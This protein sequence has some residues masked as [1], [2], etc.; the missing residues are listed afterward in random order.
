MKHIATFLITFLIGLAS[1]FADFGSV[2]THAQ[3]KRYPNELKDYEFFGS[4]RLKPIVLGSST[5]QDVQKLFGDACEKSCDYDER[6]VI[7][8]DYLSCDDCMTTEYIRDRAMCPL[9]EN[10]GT[11]EKITL[12]PKVPISIRDVPTA[13]FPKNTGGSIMFKDGSGGVSYE[14]FSDEYG[15]KYSIKRSDT[16]SMTL[17]TPGPA[18]MTGPLYSVEYGFSIETE[19]RIFKAEY[20]TCKDQTSK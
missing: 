12:T 18:Y 19:T 10:M 15:L 14:S 7:K 5:K 3:A 8:F 11:V 6:F 17:T 4:G 9:K 16:S 2:A 1:T 20:K 13:P